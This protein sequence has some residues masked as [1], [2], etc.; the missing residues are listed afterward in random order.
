MFERNS[1]F[2]RAL[3]S[4]ARAAVGRELVVIPSEGGAGPLRFLVS[5]NLKRLIQHLRLV[6]FDTVGVSLEA[7]SAASS[8][9]LLDRAK[10][11]HR[12]LLLSDSEVQRLSIDEGERIKGVSDDAS[13]VQF[14]QV[15]Q[16]LDALPA[17]RNGIGFLTRC[18]QCNVRLTPFPKD[19]ARE[20]LPLEIVENHDDFLICTRCERMHWMG[21]HTERLRGWLKKV[22]AE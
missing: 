16:S 8:Q 3:G 17:A 18:L 21:D 9:T 20:R 13:D 19:L 15:L 14:R 6:G 4:S 12:I 7:V 22:L 2:D 5:E 11:E 1:R 10:E